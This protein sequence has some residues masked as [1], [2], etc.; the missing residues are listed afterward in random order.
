MTAGPLPSFDEWIWYC[1][2]QGPKDD[3]T[4][5]GSPGYE[6]V[7]S[8]NQRFLCQDP[9]VGITPR[10]LAEYAIRL[11]RAPGF[12]VDRYSDEQIGAAIWF[13]FGNGKGEK[14]G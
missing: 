4:S 8:R 6:D 9:P 3:R 7:E 5:Y 11:F 10:I 13:I 12:V 2:E 14:R 1:F